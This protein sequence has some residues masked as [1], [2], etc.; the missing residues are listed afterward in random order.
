M[1]VAAERLVHRLGV[2]YGANVTSLGREASLELGDLGFR[3]TVIGA[4][5]ILCTVSMVLLQAEGS[6]VPRR[7]ASL[8]R[9]PPSRIRSLPRF[10]G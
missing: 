5:N 9:S 4:L 3:P 1:G 2:E 6:F 7:R 8:G 10:F